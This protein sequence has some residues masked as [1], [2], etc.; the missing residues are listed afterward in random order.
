M[1]FLPML[2]ANSCPI[3]MCN[4]HGCKSTH[5]HTSIDNSLHVF[6][7]SLKIIC[8]EN[9]HTVY[10]LNVEH[11]HCFVIGYIEHIIYHHIYCMPRK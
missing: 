4:G 5:H 7:I 6:S 2:T 8:C 9:L 11:L 10:V 1:V 3:Y